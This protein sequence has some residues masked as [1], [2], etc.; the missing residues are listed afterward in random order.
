MKRQRKSRIKQTKEAKK[1]IPCHLSRDLVNQRK[2]GRPRGHLSFL[3]PL[4]QESSGLVSSYKE[5]VCS[6]CCFSRAWLARLGK[7]AFLV[8]SCFVARPCVAFLFLLSF[9]T[10]LGLRLLSLAFPLPTSP[11]PPPRV[12][13]SG[14]E[15]L[16][17]PHSLPFFKMPRALLR[18]AAW[19]ATNELRH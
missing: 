14:G 5:R 15:I 2:F 16:P 7:A 6:R 12:R 17:V 1:R 18:L 3:L 13:G 10:R 19:Q 9:P 8:L 11:P 4:T